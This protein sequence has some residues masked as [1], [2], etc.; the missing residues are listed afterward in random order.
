MKKVELFIGNNL[1]T[2]GKRVFKNSNIFFDSDIV[3]DIERVSVIVLYAKGFDLENCKKIVDL[4]SFI[5]VND[6]VF[7]VGNENEKLLLKNELSNLFSQWI[8][9]GVNPNTSSEDFYSSLKMGLRGVSRRT[10][11]V[12]LQFGTMAE[13][14][15]ETI[16]QLMHSAIRLKKDITI[17]MWENKRGHPIIFS[18][19]LLP[20]LFS[21]RKEKGLPFLLK[22]YE[23]L[24]E[25]VPVN[26]KNILKK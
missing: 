20:I 1:F 14:K 21:L 19:K 5:Q 12:I 22:H 23:G 16:L 3:P 11:F 17:P 4:Y 25:K 10:D 13:L 9:I 2:D 15:R 24:I 8:K 18:R 6:I 7:V 26:D